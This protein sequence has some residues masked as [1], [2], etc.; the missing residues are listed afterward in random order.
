MKMRNAK[1]QTQHALAHARGSARGFT[2][3]EVMVVV[4][5][6]VIL[7]GIMVAVGVAVKRT[8]AE[9]STK[10]ALTT[11]DSA[12]TLFLKDHPEPSTANWLAALQSYPDSAAVLRKLKATSTGVPDGY[13]NNIKY[14]PSVPGVKP[15]YF[16][17]SG[18]DGQMGNTDDLFSNGASAQ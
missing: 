15:G 12:M 17:S 4:G 6:I 5:I 3:I 13:G 16:Q 9:R 18:P 8:A 2:L 10:A 1:R 11:L 7:A 14:I